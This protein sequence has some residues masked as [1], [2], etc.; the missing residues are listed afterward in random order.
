MRRWIA[1]GA[2]HVSINTMDAGLSSVDDHLAALA[3]AAD[4]TKTRLT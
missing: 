1:A 4:A 3:I 2:T